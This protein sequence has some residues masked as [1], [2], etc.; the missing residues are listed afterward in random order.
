MITVEDMQTEDLCAMCDAW[1]PIL[2]MWLNECTAADCDR[3][4][5]LIDIYSR[6]LHDGEHPV[7]AQLYDA[8]RFPRYF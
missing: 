3:F 2:R 8:H 6:C 1:Q 7:E 4:L 5:R